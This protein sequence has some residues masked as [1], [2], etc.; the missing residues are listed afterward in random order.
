MNNHKLFFILIS[1]L[2]SFAIGSI[3]EPNPS[4]IFIMMDASDLCSSTSDV[5]W[6]NLGI[7]KNLSTGDDSYVYCHSYSMTKTPSEAANELFVGDNSVFN[8]ATTNWFAN[9][10]NAKIVSLKKNGKKLAD[11]KKTNPDLIPFKFIIISEGVAGLAVREYIQSSKYKGEIENVIF[12]NTPHEG[13]GFADQVLLNGSRELDK[14]KSISDYTKL[15]P[16]IL[17]AYL[18]GGVGQLQEILISLVKEAVI[19]IAQDPGSA[20]KAVSPALDNFKQYKASM[21]YLAQDA[22]LNDNVYKKVLEKDKLI[23]AA[24]ENI[25][26]LQLLNIMPQMNGFAHPDYNIVFSYGLPTLGNGR[27]TL[28]DFANQPKNHVNK[29]KIES[30]FKTAIANAANEYG[31][32]AN[33]DD[34]KKIAEDAVN[35]IASTELKDFANKL[36]SAYGEYGGDIV[37]YA[38]DISTLSK[39]K[40]NKENIASS[41][42]TIVSTLSKYL[43]DEYKNEL[44]ST[45]IEEY[46]TD[47]S[48]LVSDI[49]EISEKLRTGRNMLAGSLSN[50]SLNFFDD[51]TFEVPSYSAL[52][53]NVL[54]F[55]EANVA[56]IGYSLNDYVKKNSGNYESIKEYLELVEDI[57]ELENLRKDIDVGLTAGCL[58]A[59]ALTPAAEKAC[60]AAQFATNVALI[61]DMNLKMKDAIAKTNQLEIAKYIALKK[62]IDKKEN[63]AKFDDYRNK[64]HSVPYNDLEKMLFGTPHVSIATVMNDKKIIPLVFSRTTDNN[65]IYSYADLEKWLSPNEKPLATYNLNNLNQISFNS[66]STSQAFTFK[67]VDYTNGYR[68]V[69]YYN[70][71]PIYTTGAIEEI[72]FQIDDYQPDQFNSIKIDFNTKVQFIFEHSNENE[73]AVYVGTNEQYSYNEKLSGNP[74]QKNGLFTFRPRTYAEKAGI[75]LEGGVEEDGPNIVNIFITNKIGR[76]SNH[77]FAFFWQATDPLIEENWP[78]SYATI[79]KLDTVRAYVNNLGY[80]FI[81]TKAELS[82]EGLDGKIK[83]ENIPVVVSP[84]DNESFHLTSVLRD[85]LMN[86]SIV[87]GEYLI[88][89][90]IEIQPEGSNPQIQYLTTIVYLDTTSPNFILHTSDKAVSLNKSNDVVGVVDSLDDKYLRGIRSFIVRRGTKDVVELLHKSHSAENSYL[91][92]WNGSN[93]SWNGW[94]DLYVQAYDFTNP[95]SNITKLLSDVSRDS[96]KSSWNTV[97]DANGEF[98]EGINGK[99]M[100]KAILVDNI[101]PHIQNEVV[102]YKSE[103]AEISSFSK[104]STDAKITLNSRDTLLISFDMIENLLERKT[105]DILVDI[106]L[107]DETNKYKKTYTSSFSVTDSKKRFEF[108]EPD[109]NRIKDGVYSLS[110][111]LTDEAGNISTKNFDDKIKVDRTAPIISTIA[112]GGVAFNSLQDL[113]PANTFVNQIDDDIR[114][115]S[116]LTCYTKVFINDGF[117]NWNEIKTLET[118]SKNG[119]ESSYTFDYKQFVNNAKDGFWYIYLGC[120]DD[121]GNFTQKVNFLGM[122][123]RY[124]QITFPN[125]NLNEIMYG[126]VLIKGIAPNP[127][128]DG[129]DNLGEINILWK[130][131]GDDDSKWMEERI[132]NLVSDLK[133]STSDRD[134]AIWNVDGLEAGD[135]VIKLSVRGCKEENCEWVSTERIVYVDDSEE[136]HDSKPEI[137]VTLPTHHVAGDNQSAFIELS[138]IPDSSNWYV[139]A[140]I[141]APSSS[142]PNVYA[143]ALETTFDPMSIC[144]YATVAEAGKKGLSVWKEKDSNNEEFWNI[145]W[146]GHA[147]GVV[148]D[149]ETTKRLPPQLK[150][151]YTISN[152]SFDTEKTTPSTSEKRLSYMVE[153]VKVGNV[154]T[155]AYNAVKTWDLNG[156]NVK[157]RF[158]AETGFIVDASSVEG[159]FEKIYNINLD[160]YKGEIVWNGLINKVYPSGELARI[161]VIAYDKNNPSNVISKSEPWYLSFDDTKIEISENSL[162]N[163]YIDF[164]DQSN[165]TTPFATAKYGFQFGLSGRSAYVTI[166]IQ[167]EKG[168]HI[169]TLMNNSFVL[170][171]ASNKANSVSWDGSTENGF[172]ATKSGN[173]KVY[174]VAKDENGKIF[175]EKYHSFNL[176]IAGNVFDA[177]KDESKNGS[178]A[179][180]RMD[181][182]IEGPTNVWRYT[183][184]PDYL[185]KANVSAQVLE[186]GDRSFTY[187]WDIANGTQYPYVYKKNRPSLG[188][189]RKRNEFEVAI[190]TLLATQ[191]YDLSWAPLCDVSSNQKIYTATLTKKKFTYGTDNIFEKN[192][193]M[194][195]NHDIIGYDNREKKEYDIL[196]KVWIFPANYFDYLSGKFEHKKDDGS[197]WTKNHVSKDCSIKVYDHAMESCNPPSFVT[198]SYT[199]WE[200]VALWTHTEIFKKSSGNITYGQNLLNYSCKPES[201]ENIYTCGSFNE[202][203]T[204]HK[205]DDDLDVHK[206]MLK[207][208]LSP[209]DKSEGYSRG[210]Y[211]SSCKNGGSD[212][213]LGVNLKLS[214]NEEYWNP[215]NWGYNNLANR[216]VRFDPTN[217]SLYGSGYLSKVSKN[218]HYDGNEWNKKDVSGGITVFEALSLPMENKV[219]NPLLFP[220]EVGNSSNNHSKSL[221]KWRFFTDVD[222]NPVH[223]IA[224]ATAG[225]NSKTF[226]SNNQKN[227]EEYNIFD[228][229]KTLPLDIEFSVAPAVS[230]SDATSANMKAIIQSSQEVE[231]P[232][233]GNKKITAPDGYVFYGENSFVSHVHTGWNEWND[234]NWD[235]FIAIKEK[236]FIRNPLTDSQYENGMTKKTAENAVP[237]LKDNNIL[238][239]IFPID[240]SKIKWNKLTLRWEYNEVPF[241]GF[242]QDTHSNKGPT[243]EQTLIVSPSSWKS[244]CKDKCV[245]SNNGSFET[246]ELAYIPSKDHIQFA[247]GSL[248]HDISLEK[249]ISQNETNSILLT[250]WAFIKSV[251]NEEIY[252]RPIEGESTLQKH[253]Y[254][255]V[256]YAEKPNGNDIERLF[257]IRRTDKEDFIEREDEIV[258]LR[259]QVPGDNVDWALSYVSNGVRYGIKTGTQ[260]KNSKDDPYQ[261]LAYKNVN[262]LQ[263]NTSFFLTYKGTGGATYYRQLDV[264]MGELVKANEIGH[265]TSMYGN[266]S[267]DFPMG[268]WENDVDVTVRTIDNDMLFETFDGLA[269]VGPIIE[270]LPSHEFPK[271]K[272]PT[273]SMTIPIKSLKDEKLEPADVKIFKPDYKLKKLIPLETQISAY[274][275][276][277]IQPCNSSEK[278][279]AYVQLSAETPTFSTFLIMDSQKAANVEPRNIDPEELANLSC[280]EM[281]RDTIWMGTDNGWLEYPYPCSGKSNYLLQLSAID[282]VASEHQ[283]ISTDPIIWNIR[284]SDLQI[285]DSSYNSTIV[286]Y[287]L[288]GS[289]IQKIGPVVKLDSVAPEIKELDVSVVENDDKKNIHVETEII[290]SG[291]ELETI[292]MEL[293][294]AG[295]LI[296]SR[297]IPKDGLLIQDFEISQKQLFECVGC[298]ASIAVIAQDK[299]HNFDKVLKQSEKIY[300]FP[301]SLVLWYPMVEG[302]GNTAQELMTKDSPYPMDMSLSKVSNPWNG[303][304]GINLYQKSDAA[305]SLYKLGVADS[306]KPFSFEFYFNAGYGK[307]ELEA[308]ILSFVGLNGWS[309]GIGSKSRYFIKVGSKT[310]YFNTIREAN[311]STHLTIVVNGDR[312]SLYRNGNYVE[313]ITLD[314]DLHYGGNGKLSIGALSENIRSAVGSIS[315]LQFYSSALTDKQIKSI[316]TGILSEEDVNTASVRA[317]SLTDREGLIVDQSCSVPGMSY[318]RLKSPNNQGHMTWK[319]DVDA[320]NYSFYILHR[321]YASDL[322]SVKIIV[323]GTSVGTYK[324][325]STGF[326]ESEKIEGLNINLKAGINEIIIQPIGNIGIAALA[327]ASSSANIDEKQMGYD[328]ASWTNPSPRIIVRMHYENQGDVTWVRPRF[329]LQNLTGTSFKDVRIRYYYNGEGEAVQAVSFYPNAP[330]SVI[331]DAGNTYYGELS[332]TEPI[333]AY[334]SPYYGNGPQIGLHRTDYYFPWDALDDPSFTDGAIDTYADARGVAVLDAD[335]FLLNEWNC[336]DADGPIEKKRKS[337]RVLAKDAKDGSN[338]SSLLTMLAENTGDTPIEGFEVRYYYRDASGKQEVDYYSSPFAATSKISAGGDLY[339]VSFLYTNTIL[340]PGEKTDFGNGVNF[341][342]HNSG[343]GV[344]FDAEDDPSHHNLN[345]VE[346]IEADS[347]VVLDING[348][349]LWGY[350]PQPR[351]S[352]QFKTKDSYEDLID[353]DGDIIYVNVTEKGT[354]TLETV[355]AIAMPLVSLFNGIWNEGEHS[356][357]I[358]NYTFTPGSYLVLRRGNEIL[359]WEIFK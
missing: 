350:A 321:N 272:Y 341:E 206:N 46:S 142:N 190:V 354:Y 65:D 305:T 311:V 297:T 166:E 68:K 282:N 242:D 276:E 328:E 237:N 179:V 287:G 256:K 101:A 325:K 208:E 32:P 33:E 9:T 8:K 95:N 57:G 40:Y 50:Y 110:I 67:N 128:I 359:S 108:I 221:F 218:H 96:A 15:I 267:V 251:E 263:G 246:K 49:N 358:S 231:Y 320:D 97:L 176:E 80:P 259:G 98:I 91:I 281:N 198:Q 196:L 167:D 89:W 83:V 161:S 14:T 54:A 12:F 41:I 230:I 104:K 355:N 195:N 312:V 301:K 105:T 202:V 250:P 26:S 317:V 124:P 159:K 132:T 87:D 74:V 122:G 343:W 204:S 151:N 274:L 291:S 345:E 273:I 219:E 313:T 349:L 37:G 332:L 284:N 233:L 154:E 254:F 302:T 227:E 48:K 318:L 239:K 169:K 148:V 352:S 338:Q 134:L 170:A 7:K 88:K 112:L 140:I 286:Y 275:D 238:S 304:Y 123:K 265:A 342:I 300:P 324:L 2:S 69:H 189:H 309:F 73:W 178:P 5:T 356:V 139:K 144:P 245:I 205:K 118:N 81:V 168:N 213:N 262:E 34:L 24:E 226:L 340:N 18:V 30:A 322:S 222:A 175:D 131:L 334:G 191:G 326:W 212:T 173:Y 306:L 31:I 23:E 266:V 337:V 55:K 149:S 299:G 165:V 138:N 316:F 194:E 164:L 129:N 271:G 192:L 248:N 339:Y 133:T 234:N 344:G 93:V 94:A 294:F 288:D 17:T 10:K 61:T 303:K 346:L 39:L 207:L 100:H 115:R 261:F 293:F 125:D 64:E 25:G 308:S 351:F 155:P 319:A 258:T 336:Y 90:N 277:K 199:D 82:L 243:G 185:L 103:Q 107:E 152:V 4:K 260:I 102:S 113:K 84:K 19:G 6:D 224:K 330:M 36:S 200:R 247:N 76:K 252:K 141:E 135:Y 220:E 16:I 44:F 156:N 184:R 315:N 244:E 279:C 158:K 215:T 353:V 42:W 216:Y 56:R 335:G 99:T 3:V 223:F 203:T 270:V 253:E 331:P 298:K 72:Q 269:P 117:A 283:G 114:N 183:G 236:G 228:G 285:L 323:N 290:E 45:F 47:I 77:K 92:R 211:S 157:I 225:S 60:K 145:Q 295:N 292:T 28:S 162:E 150:L 240:E 210:N 201:K 347:A 21:L 232:Y 11:I 146:I 289:T 147:E 280:Q 43:P 255:N 333:P 143:R 59:N 70:Y 51:G 53:K 177:S 249:F 153:S 111:I 214:V 13:S 314:N 172:V 171:G 187:Q 329:Q 180:L 174:V 241:I 85:A 119:K 137:K 20:A 120:F 268:S 130:K 29:Q 307:P 127:I 62:A 75:G 327:L 38:R 160:K 109:A 296:E 209:T 182:A 186:E 35:G 348:N 121:A 264:H 126:Q 278:E 229:Y 86:K 71:K 79:S 22:D 63:T 106:V 217:S 58:I 193:K 310:F 181:E 52:G 116:D 235:D 188:I 357:S 78:K 136:S 197:F 27:R 66:E 1:I 257:E 163:Y